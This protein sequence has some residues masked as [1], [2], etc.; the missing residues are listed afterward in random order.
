MAIQKFESAFNPKV[1]Y[2]LRIHDEDHKNLL[3][4]GDATVK[5][6]TPLDKLTPN[7]K[8]LNLA[9]KNR[10]KDYTNTA[11]VNYELLYTEVAVLTE[12]DEDGKDILLSFRDHK[13]HEV[14]RNSHIDNVK[15]NHSTSREWY[16]IDLDTAKAA[17]RAVKDGK[18]NLS[19]EQITEN[20]GGVDFRPEQKEAVENTLKKFK[21][22][23]RMLWSMKMRAGKSLSSLEVVRR[24]G[25][26]KTLILTHRPVVD[27]GWYDD[28]NKIFYEDSD[29][30]TYGSKATGATLQD[31]LKTKKN[32]VYFASMQDLRGSKRVGGKF[33]KNEDVFGLDWDLVI[34]DEAHEGTTTMLGDR[35]IK[36]VVKEGNGYDTKFLALSGTPFNIL[37]DFDDNI[38]TWDYI[39]EQ[40][41]KAEWSRNGLDHN[42]YEELPEMRIFTYD[43]G[44]LMY[45]ER[46][47]ELED[48]AF[49]FREFF[50]TWTGDK[51]KDGHPLPA[52][53][54]AGDF[55]HEEDVLSFLNLIS[56]ASEESQ[57]PY[58]TEEYRNLF[59]HT[60]WMIPGV[61][62]ARALSKMLKNH[63]VF[64]S[65][66]FE[67]VNVAGDGD[68]EEEYDEALKKVKKAIKAAG[69]DG[70]TITLSCGKLTTGVTVPEW[71]AVFYLAGSFSTSASSYL[72]TIFRVQ[73]PCNRYGKMKQ[74][75]YVFDFAPDRTLKMVTEAAA[76]STKAGGTSADDRKIMGEFLNYCPVISIDGT[77]MK[78][79]NTSN[80]LQQLKRAYAE[81]AVRTG[82][83]DINIYS[84]ELLRLTENELSLLNDIKGIIGTSNAA[85]HT[86]E[87]D[88]NAQGFTDEE[89]EKIKKA[90]KKPKRQLTEEEKRL[91]KELA[92]KRKQKKDAI[93]VLRGISIRMP[94]LIYGADIPFEDDVTIEQLP[95]LIDDASWKEFMPEGITKEK[96]KELTKFYD[97][98]I[99][100]AAG[101]RIRNIAKSAD[102][103]PPVERV[104][105]IAELFSCFKNPDKETVLTPWRVVNMH[106]GDCFGGWCFFNEEFSDTLE[107]P[108][109]IDLGKVTAETVA[110][111]DAKILEINSKTGLYPLYITASI[112]LTRLHSLE[113]EEQTSE[114][115]DELWKDVVENNVFVVCK[116]P[117]AKTITQRTLVGYKPYKINAH[118]F[119]DLVNQFQEK[120]DQTIKK[121][122]KPSFW[123]K[124][125]DI[126]HINAITGNPPYHLIITAPDAGNASLS[127]Q[128]YPAFIETSIKLGADY[129]SLV[130]PSRW[131]TANAQDG[132]FPKLR[133]F[134]KTNSN[135]RKIIHYN[136]NRMLFPN[137]AM[138][139][140]NYFLYENGYDG[141]VEF[142][143]VIDET[144]RLTTNRPLFEP[145][146]SIII[147]SN[148]LIPF[149]EKV[150]N[151]AD[152]QPLSDLSTGRNPFGVVGKQ[153]EKRTKTKPF[154]DSVKVQCAHEEF[155][156]I[157]RSKVTKNVE[158]MDA[159]KI[160]TSKGNGGAG[161]LADDKPVAIIGRAFVA[162]P[163][164][165]CTDSLIPFGKFK[166]KEEAKNL[167][168]YMETKFLRFFVGILKSS[169]NIYQVVY[170][171]VPVQDFTSDSDIDWS[172]SVED[173]DRQL[174][175]KYGFTDEERAYIENRI[176]PM[177]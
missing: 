109:F 136:D 96:F 132:S 58:A 143:E 111:P 38:Y 105:K 30:Y 92:E 154:K 37:N 146:A 61:K 49:N 113:E 83:D 175:D 60:L 156:F 12:K 140:V 125:G 144:T 29:S 150:R 89:Y 19:G 112:F 69:E 162:G 79:Y 48:K 34:V 170:E 70:Y 2:V 164:C 172:C 117:M 120:S 17:I 72:Q 18:R 44:K 6:D 173:V 152:F 155:R 157:E 64:G 53:T 3:K 13:V 4:I 20:F 115:Q 1:I 147:S 39:M 158:I 159:W 100:L 41:A 7:C 24:A 128:L 122:T 149:I 137:V 73:S 99:F 103:L 31:L 47:I 51:A 65:G 114:K 56:Q 5:T 153:I 21:T 14:L 110:N 67:I 16:N 171:Y 97:A 10:I 167:K 131:F 85:H 55:F 74:L 9:A 77:M 160:F 22:Q 169:Q 118:A 127:K 133:E 107:E 108:R 135:F 163:G 28:F 43:L 84:D 46:Y 139:P 87:I 78:P 54:E 50:R 57:Y 91:L 116:T 124:K 123:G 165:V 32:F 81:R 130:T 75:C 141:D 121:L 168:K 45:D 148:K 26:S 176:K 104:N 76:I 166:T 11:A 33:D 102:F 25:F 119:D 88:I 35:V 129:V 59:K 80:L 66:A 63:P 27:A 40:K 126:M 138:G 95:A 106:M 90:K 62:E 15:I 42:P 134:V 23:N 94:L 82:F 145:G 142:T 177:E 93:S 174:F 161:M 68:E 36:E 151:R 98:D 101:R 52:G 86:N 8:E 71:T